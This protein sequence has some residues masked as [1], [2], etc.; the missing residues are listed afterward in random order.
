MKIGILTFHY[1]NNFGAVLQAYALR[2]CLSQM[3]HEVYFV[4]YK[5]PILLHR[6]DYI[7]N[8]VRNKSLLK[9]VKYVI[10]E[11]GCFNKKRKKYGEINSYRRCM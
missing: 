7:P 9:K 4:D 1:C 3:G 11:L 6:Y 8:Y 5:L 2:E 10:R